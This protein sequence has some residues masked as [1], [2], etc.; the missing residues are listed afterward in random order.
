MNIFQIF[1]F[2]KLSILFWIHNKMV[3]IFVLWTFFMKSLCEEF[4]KIPDI[5]WF[6]QHFFLNK[7]SN[8]LQLLKLVIFGS[9]KLIK[10]R[11]NWKEI[12]KGKRNW[13]NGHHAPHIV[14]PMKNFR[15]DEAL[16]LLRD[17]KPLCKWVIFFLLFTN[18]FEFSW[19]FSTIVFF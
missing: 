6:W 13:T 5:L 2:W 8:N 14:R 12:R 17:K 11:K 18:L 15:V 16:A 1:Y 3:I 10:K 9:Q 7:I 19:T 4:S